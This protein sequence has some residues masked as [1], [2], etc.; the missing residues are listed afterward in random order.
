MGSEVQLV[1]DTKSIKLYCPIMA[2]GYIYIK[3]SLEKI[4]VQII[5][6]EFL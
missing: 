5:R 2:L 6:E 4:G 1:V 3:K